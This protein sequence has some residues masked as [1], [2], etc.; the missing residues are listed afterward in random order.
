MV[1]APS[2]ISQSSHLLTSLCKCKNF[3]KI[4]VH[5]LH[6]VCISFLYTNRSGFP[7]ARD[8]NIL[9]ITVDECDSVYAYRHRLNL[10]SDGN[11]LTD[12]LNNAKLSAS[13][14]HPESLLD[15]L[16]Q[17]A[18]CEVK[19]GGRKRERKRERE[20]GGGGVGGGKSLTNLCN[21]V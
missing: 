16:L 3:T 21:D 10:T 12:E 7:C 4:V 9:R 1:L 2:L 5:T 6:A 11:L 17:V 18:V 19:C 8:A 15:A 14:D 13:P 20:R